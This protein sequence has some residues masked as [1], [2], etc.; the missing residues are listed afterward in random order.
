[1][2]NKTDILLGFVI[3]LIT[4]LLGCFLFIRLFTDYT[5]VTGIEL[6]QTDGK[7]GKIITLG[8]VLDL[9]VF[10]SLLKSHKEFMARGVILAVI[11]LT[12]VTL[13]V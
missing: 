10:W 9:I 6:L 7:L 11:V 4:S 2:K 13:F 12:I 1:M 5:F 8:T 3:G